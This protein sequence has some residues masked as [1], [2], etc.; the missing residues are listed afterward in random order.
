MKKFPWIAGVFLIALLCCRCGNNAPK[1]IP[2]EPAYRP[3]KIDIDPS[4]AYL[5]PEQSM[6][7]M[8]LPKGYHLQ[9]VA[10]EP[11]VQ[12]PV[13]IAWDGDGRMYVA[14]M[15]TYMKDVDGNNENLPTSRIVRLEDTNGDGIMDKKTVF[16]DS[17]VLPRMILPLDDRLVVNETYTYDLWSYRDTNGDGVADEKKLMYHSDEKDTRNLEHQR[18]GL[19]WN[20]D[21]MIYV[22]RDPVRYRYASNM[23]QVDSLPEGP[24]GQWGLAKDNYGRLFFSSAGGETPAL[25]FQQNPA[26][27]GLNIKGQRADDFDAVWPVTGTPDVQGGVMRVRPDS[28]LNHFTASCGQSIFRGDRLPA[29][30]LGN[31]FICEPVGRLIRRAIVMDDHGKIVLKNA[32][33]K[34]EFLSSTDMNFRPV[35]TVT[36]PDGCMYIVDMYHG[37]IQE[38]NWTREGS[39]L[40]PR[41]QRL[42]LDKNIGRGRIYRLV[43][44][45]YTPGPQPHL[46]E[47]SSSQLV[48]YLNH[49]NGW[50]R[51]NAQKL[52]VIRGDKSVV[53]A[54]KKMALGKEGF[55]DKLAFWKDKPTELGRLHALWTLEGLDAMDKNTLFAAFGDE[56]PHIRKAAVWISEKYIKQDDEE[57]LDKLANLVSDNNADV[58]TQ[59]YLSLR[60]GHSE[61]AKD[62]TAKILSQNPKNEMLVASQ[63]EYEQLI[64]AKML[65][66]TLTGMTDNEKDLVLDGAEIFNNL[67]ATCHGKTGEGIS[68]HVAPALANQPRVIGDKKVLIKILLN[69]LQ[70]RRGWKR[71]PRRN[72][73]N[74][75]Q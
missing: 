27:G 68:T 12:E 21:N 22:S 63:N 40:R 56:N 1:E 65:E 14:E 36:G 26:Y 46:L 30:L 7:T 35:N 16:I 69:G 60:Q 74:G 72:A 5:S 31:L 54:L 15:R 38:S 25:D 52:L 11:M 64:K 6:K 49:P 17:L 23:L 42:G 10:S 51:D 61:K 3:E 55:L 59:L 41:I 2:E 50:W 45:G 37:I 28:T 47:A 58:K 29:N 20:I 66:S 9:L 34:A 43:H 53:P 48:N 62:L 57:V 75:R 44:D 71:L 18:S 32:Y 24:S 8:H 33:D 39:Y 19:T 13:A 67:C 4:G 70:G 73:L